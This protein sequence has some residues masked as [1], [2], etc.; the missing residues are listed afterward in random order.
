[1]ILWAAFLGNPH[2]GIDINPDVHID[3]DI[4]TTSRIVDRLPDI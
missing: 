2:L 4:D 3:L 1:M